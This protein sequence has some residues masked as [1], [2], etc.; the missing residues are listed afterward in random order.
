MEFYCHNYKFARNQ[1]WLCSA[2]PYQGMRATSFDPAGITGCLEDTGALP[3]IPP[4]TR[5]PP[6]HRPPRPDL[7]TEFQQPLTTDSPLDAASQEYNFIS[8]H[9]HRRNPANAGALSGRPCPG[10]CAHCQNVEQHGIRLTFVSLMLPKFEIVPPS[11]RSRFLTMTWD[12]CY[13]K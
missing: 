8:E 6:A 12:R 1:G 4:R 10:E 2:R 5:F 7:V 11:G 13:R 3:Q 9:H